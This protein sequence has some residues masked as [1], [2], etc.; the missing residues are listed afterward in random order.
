MVSHSRLQNNRALLRD[1]WL[2]ASSSSRFRHR[3]GIACLPSPVARVRPQHRATSAMPHASLLNRSSR[4]SATC[5]AIHHAAAFE[6]TECRHDSDAML[7]AS[8]S[9]QAFVVDSGFGDLQRREKAAAELLVDSARDVKRRV[10]AILRVVE[11]VAVVIVGNEIVFDGDVERVEK[12]NQR[13]PSPKRDGMSRILAIDFPRAASEANATLQPPR[14]GQLPVA[15][16]HPVDAGREQRH[17]VGRCLRAEPRRDGP[18]RTGRAR[19][20]SE[21]PSV[22]ILRSFR[23]VGRTQRA[24]TAATS[25]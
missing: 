6:F 21:I 19:P 12:L 9:E 22:V 5:P 3:R 8:F 7:P 13:R 25:S 18:T 10:A 11:R 20:R 14:R 23:Q 24:T 2:S 15:Q 17:A 4:G 16:G 1:S